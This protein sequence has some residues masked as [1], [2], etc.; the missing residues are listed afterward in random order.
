M[1]LSHPAATRRPAGTIKSLADLPE[2]II[3]T[4]IPSAQ[5][6]M[7]RYPRALRLVS[8]LFAVYYLSPVSQLKAIW[9]QFSSFIISEV[10]VSSEEDLYEFASEWIADQRTIRADNTLNALSSSMSSSTI[11]RHQR[12]SSDSDENIREPPQKAKIRY[13]QSQGLQIFVYKRRLFFFSRSYGFGHSYF[14]GT[15]RRSE[16][17]HLRCLGRSTEP[18]R[19]LLQEIFIL[20]KD[21]EKSLT[22]IRRPQSSGYGDSMSWSRITAKQKRALDTVILEG[23]QKQKI[24]ADIT[25]YM[26]SETQD[27]YAQH[28]IPYRRGYLFH[29]PPGVGKT[30]FALALAAK[31]GLDVY[32]LSLTDKSLSDSSMLTLLT[33]L[34]AR[35]LLLLEDIDTAGLNRNTREAKAAL[36]RRKLGLSPKTDKDQDKQENED[37]EKLGALADASGEDTGRVTLSGLLNAIDGVASPEGH[38]L[39]M[40]TNKPDDLDDALVRA[41]RISVRVAFK[42]AS[43]VQARELFERMYIKPP[44][45]YSDPDLEGGRIK[46]CA[47]EFAE[48][49]PDGE[50]SPADLQEFL[51]VH[52]RSPE[53][54]VIGVKAWKTEILEER[55]RREEERKAER[56]AMREERKLRKKSAKDKEGGDDGEMGS[57]DVGGFLK[58]NPKLVELVRKFGVELGPLVEAEEEE[59]KKENEE[60]LNGVAASEEDTDEDQKAEKNGVKDDEAEVEVDDKA[61]EAEVGTTA[62]A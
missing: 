37:A 23:E 8:I 56:E 34:P 59:N 11:R 18:I 33:Q 43:R 46:K 31:F 14:N 16:L 49:I 9:D 2:Y 39:I 41:G 53:A 22:I 50:F 6:L 19:E 10:M 21:K 1:S 30:S 62:A 13:E 28:G 52:K 42:N 12:H 60:Q 44:V 36:V 61:V 40:T 48:Q 54:A 7:A 4:F 35:A 3:S 17:L 55:G 25:E 24:I 45:I 5:P 29:G 32:V 15:Y 27:F 57:I 51:L 20:H 26:D 47:T 38:I 58:K